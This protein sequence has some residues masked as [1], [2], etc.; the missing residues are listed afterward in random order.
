[1]L[2]NV[3][4]GAKTKDLWAAELSELWSELGLADVAVLQCESVPSGVGIETAFKYT[5]HTH[6][7][8]I[9]AYKNSKNYTL[10]KGFHSQ[11]NVLMQV[12]TNWTFKL[13]KLDLFEPVLF[14]DMCHC[15]QGSSNCCKCL[16]WCFVAAKF[17]CVQTAKLVVFTTI[18]FCAAVNP[19]TLECSKNHSS[20]RW[21]NCKT[22]RGKYVLGTVTTYERETNDLVLEL[23]FE[24]HEKVDF[25][26]KLLP[27]FIFHY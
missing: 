18:V 1:M 10:T 3:V 17:V 14:C 15:L 13:L 23:R 11:D 8:I 21:R 4:N 27:H 9:V 20:M 25:R 26:I 2:F 7:S 12:S 16:L 19:A 5:Q 22:N 24:M 6:N